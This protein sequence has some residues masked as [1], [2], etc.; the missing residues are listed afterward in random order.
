MIKSIL[1]TGGGSGIGAALALTLAKQDCH[2][3]VSG[4]RH[5]SLLAIADQSPKITALQGDVTHTNDQD[6]FVEALSKLPAPRAIFHG[7]GFFQIGLLE[8]LSYS[9][10]QYSFETNVT[11]RWA[12][13]TKCSQYLE[14]G[15][16]LFV[17]SD[18]GKN[19]REG[20]A[21]YS[22]AQS[23][24]ETLRRALQAEWL[25]REISVSS[26]KPGLVDTE[27]VQGFLSKSETEFP[28]KKNFQYYIERG[29]FV[30]PQTVAAFAAWLLL[31][32]DAERFKKTDWDIRES[33]RNHG[34]AGFRLARY[35]AFLVA[36]LIA[37][38]ATLSTTTTHASNAEAV[39]QL[40]IDA[41]IGPATADYILEGIRV[42]EEEG[43]AAIVLEMDT[44][45][46]LDSAMR[47]IIKGILA[48]EVPV[49]TYVSPS[50]SR[51]A[52]AG[53]YILYAS[54]VAAMA[55]A[56]NLGAAT[57]VQIGGSPPASPM[58]EP[59]KPDTSDGDAADDAEAADSATSPE[60]PA[61]AMKAKMVN[62]AVAYIK[63]L[64]ELRGRNADWAERAV[65][66]AVSLTS[67]EALKEN[68]IDI[69]ASDVDE[70]LAQADG[71]LVE[72]DGDEATLE[73]EGLAIELLEPDWR[74]ELLTI[75]TDPSVAYLLMLV[76]IY[77][78][79]LEG[80]NPGAL[81][82]GIVGA[83]C[84]LLALFAFQV[85]PVNYA[86]LALMLLGIVLMIAEGFAP[87]FGVLGIGGLA[88]FVFGSVILMDSDVPGFGIS[89]S[90]IGGTA[91]AGGLAV[92]GLVYMMLRARNRPVVSGAEKIVGDVGEVLE[93]FSGEGAILLEGERWAA[94]SDIGLQRG[95][96]VR[97]VSLDGLIV[98]V[99]PLD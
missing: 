43:Y 78:L 83:I 80:Y 28:A 67:S 88:A 81:V 74:T 13:S 40:Q 49:I 7:A 95:Q 90:I 50:G 82:P 70:L 64:A 14:G 79:L 22:I 6:S 53:T 72:V 98:T 60:M 65:R 91:T 85:L 97:I 76:G 12:L 3:L 93:D 71:M 1:V 32:V 89:R 18:S 29:E 63:G 30:K 17:G 39:L 55:P 99:T 36:G 42:A 66:E 48:S 47:D 10:W 9:E 23:A 24:S 59:E 38:M 87:S 26:F 86:G 51:A 96:K 19:I 57:P 2:V 84:L 68:V 5:S 35:A 52:S 73:T 41:A 25:E 61:D 77:G 69:V 8:K 45:G 92:L 21:A 75:I 62:D 33:V 46:G 37:A 4:R 54:H 58:P 31:K 15:R 11:S 44:P 56:S 27:M 20:A 94:R 16:V 34:H